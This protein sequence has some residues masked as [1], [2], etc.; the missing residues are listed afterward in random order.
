M[1]QEHLKRILNTPMSKV[2]ESFE[3][4]FH[5]DSHVSCMWNYWH[6]IA[7]KTVKGTVYRITEGLINWDER[8]KTYLLYK[9]ENLF[10]VFA[11]VQ[12][13]K[14]YVNNLD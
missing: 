8:K 2:I 14:D 3:H 10:A 5:Q 11:S 6:P 4:V 13:A 12:G 9:N 7:Q 1:T